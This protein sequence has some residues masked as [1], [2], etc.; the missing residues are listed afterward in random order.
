MF[1]PHCGTQLPEQQGSR[2]PNC[3]AQTST[4]ANKPNRALQIILILV[5]AALA[6]PIVLGFIAGLLYVRH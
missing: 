2:C 4:K 3:G 6:A 1:C 5:A